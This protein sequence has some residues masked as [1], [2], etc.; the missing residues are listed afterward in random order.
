MSTKTS[1]EPSI[2]TSTSSLSTSAALTQIRDTLVEVQEAIEKIEEVQG[3]SKSLQSLRPK[4]LDIEDLVA[5]DRAHQHLL[6]LDVISRVLDKAAECQKNHDLLVSCHGILVTIVSTL[7]DTSC[8]HL[9]TYALKGLVYLRSTSLPNLETELESDLEALNYP[10]CVLGLED[11][12]ELVKNQDFSNVK[13]FQKTY[14]ILD[15]LQ[16]PSVILKQF[17]L[18]NTDPAL[19]VLRPLKKRF[20]YHFLG[21]KKTNNSIKPEWYLQ[22]VGGWLKQSKRFFQAVNIEESNFHRFSRGLCEQVLEKLEK[23][24]FANLA[25]DVTSSHMIDEILTY[26]QE[27]Y[28]LGVDEDVLPLVVL[29]DSEIFKKWL[30]LERKFAFAKIDDIMLDDQS[31]TSSNSRVDISK[32]T[33]TFVTLL[34]SITNRFKHLNTDCQ[35]KF[36][37]LQSE[38]IE[39]MRL[40]F[41][42]IVRQEQSFPLSEKYCLIM[43]SSQHLIN[44]MTSWSGIP[45]YLQLELAKYGDDHCSGLFGEVIGGFEF[46]VKDLTKNLGED[47]TF[48]FY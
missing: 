6:W 3:K 12:E 14:Q 4:P 24:V 17:E 47:F 27:F 7:I 15:D 43:N 23:D 16:L 48:L 34:Q 40:R 38:L 18:K 46:F 21:A 22:Q 42:Q 32:C 33:E 28:N 31:W 5:L 35:L 29:L 10:K 9:R 11:H 8:L 36:V 26:S 2:S 37:E 25:D 1:E 30:I 39:D 20:K 44:V 19:R 13:K 45:L 41:A